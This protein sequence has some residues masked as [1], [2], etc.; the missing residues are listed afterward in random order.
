MPLLMDDM[1]DFLLFEKGE[2]IIYNGIPAKALLL[3][4]S[5]EINYEDD[6][7]MITDFLF[8]T[9]D[10]IQYQ[11]VDWFII[12]Q[13]NK[14]QS[15]KTYRSR[16]RKV[17]QSFKMILNNRVEV[18]PAIFEPATQSI[19]TSATISVWSGNLKAI[20][21]DTDLAKK[22]AI[23]LEFLKMG[24]K[25]KVDGF[26]T[27]H[28]GLRTLYCEKVSLGSNDDQVN[29][30]ADTNLLAHYSL[31]ISNGSAIQMGVTQTLQLNV[32]ATATIGGTLS[33]LT[34][35]VINFVSSDP[36]KARVDA[37]GLVT[38]LNTGNVNITATLGID[39]GL[40]QPATSSIAITIVS[41]PQDNYTIDIVN[42]IGVSIANNA[43]RTF[44]G[45]RKNNGF[46]VPN[47]QF[48][49][50]VIPGTTPTTKYTLT[51]INDTSCTI[52][53]LGYPYTITLRCYDRSNRLLYI[54]KSIGLKAI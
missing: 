39:N 38:F 2:D 44:V 40:D 48:D 21:Q 1:F 26:T 32:V 47:S 18:F 17:E 30:I 23:N 12:G 3:D 43:T 51:I 37:N 50:E 15:F 52:K 24:A 5:S 9:G 31:A 19:S 25:W 42:A 4:A 34:N 49:F 7:E 27:E 54:D 33:A 45:N 35:P 28:A 22:I 36:T 10:R 14:H 46:D 41:S 20:I 29:E 6:K 53:C 11:N 16:I 8:K 13:V